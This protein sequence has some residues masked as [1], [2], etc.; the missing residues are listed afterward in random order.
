M[1]GILAICSIAVCAAIVVAAPAAAGWSLT[2]AKV[3]RMLMRDATVQLSPADKSSLADE[4]RREVARFRGL[5]LAAQ[6]TGDTESWWIYN[7]VSSRYFLALQSV[8]DG[9]A[10]E[11]AACRGAGK[12][13]GGNRFQRFNCHAT[14]EV[15]HIPSTQLESSTDGALPVVIEGDPRDVGPLMTQFRVRVSGKSAIEYR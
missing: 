7:S 5:Q 2:E 11:D 8:R 4:L 3:E 6:E 9:L 15:L 12:A 1:R 13:T 14:S 10:I